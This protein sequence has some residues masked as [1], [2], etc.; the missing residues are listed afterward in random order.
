MPDKYIENNQQY[1][2]LSADEQKQAIVQNY[3][4]IKKQ[5]ALIFYNFQANIAALRENP[6]DENA[7]AEVRTTVAKL[8]R[9]M[10]T[11]GGLSRLASKSSFTSEQ[12]VAVSQVVVSDTSILSRLRDNLTLMLDQIK[13]SQESDLDIEFARRQFELLAKSDLPEQS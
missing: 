6:A 9:M 12:Q 10:Q 1:A 8:T 11:M 13:K 4:M 2:E 7:L 5:G 3:A